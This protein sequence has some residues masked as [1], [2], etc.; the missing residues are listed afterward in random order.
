MYGSPIKFSG[1]RYKKR[2]QS[3]L[4]F[5]KSANTRKNEKR[6][7]NIY[8]RNGENSN[9]GEKYAWYQNC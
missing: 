4:N 1:L 9:Y 8:F 5:G 2:Y 7:I 3:C 6:A